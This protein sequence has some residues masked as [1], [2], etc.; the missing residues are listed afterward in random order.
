MQVF[1]PKTTSYFLPFKYRRKFFDFFYCLLFLAISV[2]PFNFLPFS[3]SIIATAKNSLYIPNFHT[4]FLASINISSL[5]TWIFP[6]ARRFRPEGLR[7]SQLLADSVRKDFGFSNYS[8]IASGST[9]IFPIARRLR[10]EG[11]RFSQLL[12]DC[13]RKDFGFPNCSQIPFGSTWVFPTARKFR[14]EALGFFQLLA[15]SVWKHLGFSNCL[16]VFT[17][18]LWVV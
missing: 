2:L 10:L 17:K 4:Y 16:R 11:L 12:A 6:I 13:V 15:N 18:A 7:F 8:Q 14:L 5:G 9:W 3:I 1:S